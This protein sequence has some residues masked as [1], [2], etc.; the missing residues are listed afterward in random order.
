MFVILFPLGLLA[1][2]FRRICS[3]QIFSVTMS[4][5]KKLATTRLSIDPKGVVCFFK[6]TINNSPSSFASHLDYTASRTERRFF[7]PSPSFRL[8]SLFY[9]F[10]ILFFFIPFPSIKYHSILI[11]ITLLIRMSMSTIF[12][13]F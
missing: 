11:L 5:I 9:T 7:M 3:Q 10:S 4:L 2:R 8:L 6:P 12:D 1:L 13:I